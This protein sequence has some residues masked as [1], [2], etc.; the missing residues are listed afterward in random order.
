MIN[1]IQLFSTF[2]VFLCIE[3]TM[4]CDVRHKIYIFYWYV[5]WITE[6]YNKVLY[7]PGR[8]TTLVNKGAVVAD[9]GTYI[10]LD[11]KAGKVG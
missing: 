11:G 5:T 10:D 2:L 9:Y 1:H 7:F 3:L 6:S 8:P 4:N